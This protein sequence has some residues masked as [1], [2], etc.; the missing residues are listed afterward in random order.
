MT[1]EQAHA[2]APICAA[3]VTEMRE[4]FGEDQ[5]KVLWVR[6]GNFSKGK[7]DEDERANR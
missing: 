1:K 7:H 4:Q 2:L 3:F 6:E 5:V